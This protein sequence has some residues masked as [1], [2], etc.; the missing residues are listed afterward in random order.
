MAAA[1]SEPVNRR[2]Q[3]DGDIISSVLPGVGGLIPTTSATRTATADLRCTPV[4][5][6]VSTR[7][8]AFRK[9]PGLAPQARAMVLSL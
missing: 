9:E 4:S 6:G 3:P 8:M 2:H 7:L 1:V 5:F